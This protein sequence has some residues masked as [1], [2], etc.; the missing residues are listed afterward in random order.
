MLYTSPLNNFGSPFLSLSAIID[1]DKY[2]HEYGGQFPFLLKKG[3]KG[4]VPCGTP[5]Y[6]MIPI[7]RETWVSEVL[8][9]NYEDNVKKSHELRKYIANG[10]RK[11]FWQKKEFN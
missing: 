11:L 9:F 3:F 10:Y 7:K 2:H 8:K 5:M 4:V 6:V 1:S